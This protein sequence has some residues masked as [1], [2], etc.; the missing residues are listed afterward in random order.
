MPF[1]A[2]L[3][4]DLAPLLAS[5]EQFSEVLKISAEQNIALNF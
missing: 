5:L 2:K 4:H 3:L 1:L